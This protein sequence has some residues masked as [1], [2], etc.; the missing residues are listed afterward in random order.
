V[1]KVTDRR[2]K[3]DT[4]RY[5]VDSRRPS[6]PPKRARSTGA[7]LLKSRTTSSVEDLREETAPESD[8]NAAKTSVMPGES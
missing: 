7:P 1:K 4:Y 5:Q 2:I 8:Y 6:L 3:P